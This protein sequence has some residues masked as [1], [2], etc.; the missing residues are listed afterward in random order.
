MDVQI[1]D[2]Q[3]EATNPRKRELP[4]LNT[5]GLV[6]SPRHPLLRSV[7]A[8]S[9][10]KS[11]ETLIRGSLNGPGILLPDSTFLFFFVPPGKKA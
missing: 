10:R 1:L 4:G 3:L 5:V 2:T 8:A 6:F 9:C 7:S 11:D